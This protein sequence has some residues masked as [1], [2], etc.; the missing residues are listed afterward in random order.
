MRSHCKAIPTVCSFTIIKFKALQIVRQEADGSGWRRSYFRIKRSHGDAGWCTRRCFGFAP[1]Q[2]S[3]FPAQFFFFFSF[4][5][6]CSKTKLVQ[7]ASWNQ[8]W[9][10]ADSCRFLHRSH[11]TPAISVSLSMCSNHKLLRCVRGV[12]FPRSCLPYRSDITNPPISPLTFRF[13][14]YA[15]LYMD[16]C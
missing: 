5:W 10:I 2:P 16:H 7:T 9:W 11:I 14:L 4:L 1:V 6:L 13:F 15:C 3:F 12:L 8:W